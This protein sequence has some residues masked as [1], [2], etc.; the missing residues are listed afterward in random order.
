MHEEKTLHCVMIIFPMH[1][2]LVC[3]ILTSFTLFGV[4]PTD[5]VFVFDVVLH[6]IVGNFDQLAADLDFLTMGER[7]HR[8]HAS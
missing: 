5:E 1:I 6:N 7:L 4:A 2:K 8:N 3:N